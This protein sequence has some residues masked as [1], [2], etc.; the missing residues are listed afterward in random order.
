[1]PDGNH[2][3]EITA[4][5]MGDYIGDLYI[6]TFI[7]N[8]SSKANFAVE[9]ISE[10]IENLDKI[11]FP[12][13]ATIIVIVIITVGAGILVYLKKYRS[14]NPSIFKKIQKIN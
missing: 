8:G 11:P 2:T 7:I 5:E 1:M 13:T 9:T 6:Y 3:I 10:P 4:C 12:M 14:R